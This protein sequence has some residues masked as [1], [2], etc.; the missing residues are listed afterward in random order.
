MNSSPSRSLRLPFAALVLFLL[1]AG[2]G[3]KGSLYL[4][5]PDADRAKVEAG[6]GK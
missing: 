1:L 3:S 6:K 2:C 5:E 4:P